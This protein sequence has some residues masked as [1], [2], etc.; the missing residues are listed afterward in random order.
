MGLLFFAVLFN[1]DRQ[2]HRFGRRWLSLARSTINVYVML[3]LFPLVLLLPDLDHRVQ[4]GI[5]L[6]LTAFSTVRQFVCWSAARK[7][8]CEPSRHLLW[9]LGWLLLAPVA[10]YVVIGYATAQSLWTRSPFR[11]DLNAFALLVLFVVSLRNS[12]NLVLQHDGIIREET[13]PDKGSH[14]EDGAS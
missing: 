6:I 8:K 7:L 9:R 12:W 1:V 11:H 2:G 13:S 3:C 4:A 14:I 10:T 5:I